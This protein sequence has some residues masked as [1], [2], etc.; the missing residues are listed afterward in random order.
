MTKPRR[1]SPAL[2]G[3]PIRKTRKPGMTGGQTAP[4]FSDADDEQASVRSVPSLPRCCGLSAST[5]TPRGGGRHEA[6]QHPG[7]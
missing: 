4:W 6:L 1:L 7:V 5:L 3:H 2:R